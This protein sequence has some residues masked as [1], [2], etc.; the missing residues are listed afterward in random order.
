MLAEE[1]KHSYTS[2]AAGSGSS[3]PE[4]PV[5]LS[6]RCDRCH[7]KRAFRELSI[8]IRQSCVLWKFL[9]RSFTFAPRL[10]ESGAI[11]GIPYSHGT[12]PCG[13]LFLGNS[14]PVHPRVT[15]PRLP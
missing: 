9:N 10:I 11:R 4:Y 2:N 7:R 14:P 13:F 5:W 3:I 1:G 6:F 12:R 15:P 8:G